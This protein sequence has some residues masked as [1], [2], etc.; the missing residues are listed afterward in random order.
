[1]L[2]LTIMQLLIALIIG[3]ILHE[4]GHGYVAYKLGDDTAFKAG[5]VTLNPLPHIDPIGTI[6]IPMIG[7]FLGGFLFGW[8]KPVPVTHGNLRD[9]RYGMMW[10]ALAGPGMNILVAIISAIGAY[11]LAP[12]GATWL[13]GLCIATVWLNLVLAAFNMLPVPP[14]DGGHVLRALLPW[15][16]YIARKWIIYTKYGFW[17]L[18]ALLFLPSMLLG[19][20]PLGTLVFGPITHFTEYFASVVM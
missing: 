17:A 16:P 8:A 15:S 14:L 6:L 1:M 4:F 5:R 7:L 20:D 18:L 19:I 11:L 9:P 2:H 12:L 10:V 3:M 13:V